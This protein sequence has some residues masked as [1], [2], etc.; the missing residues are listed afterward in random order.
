MEG[1]LEGDEQHGRKGVQEAETP[2]HLESERY[3]Q[4]IHKAQPRPLRICILL[5]KHGV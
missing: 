1:G 5:F 3:Y 2:E 4:S